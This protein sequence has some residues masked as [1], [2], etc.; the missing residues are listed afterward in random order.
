MQAPAGPECPADEWAQGWWRHARAVPSPNFGPRPAGPDGQVSLVV[1]HAI[2]LP[3][4]RFGG[5]E[6]EQLFTNAL[7]W[8]AHPYFEALRGLRVSAHFFI[9][10]QGEVVQFVSTRDRA[11]HAGES[12]WRGRQA[13]NDHSVGVELEVL[14]GDAFE[15]AQYS[16]LQRLLRALAREHPLSDVAGHEHI[17]PGRKGDPGPGFDWSSL[18]PTLGELSL[19]GPAAASGHEATGA[20]VHWG[21]PSD[22]H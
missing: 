9:R 3:P 5:P 20:P 18:A 11:W 13:C 4:G 16:A 17:A 22:I 12:Q 15:P 21:F 10:R 6:V 1:V 8:Q 19:R 7:D 2:S 14:E